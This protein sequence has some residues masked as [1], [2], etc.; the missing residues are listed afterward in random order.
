MP[1]GAFWNRSFVV[2]FF[3]RA[4][5]F[6]FFFFVVDADVSYWQ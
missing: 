3:G 4:P 2:G 1:R 6:F 5:F